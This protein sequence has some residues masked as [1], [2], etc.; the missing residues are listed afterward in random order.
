M[1]NDSIHRRSRRPVRSALIRLALAPILFA[2]LT[3]TAAAKPPNIVLML[4]DNVGFGELGVYAGGVL[5]GAPTPRLDRLAAEGMRFTNFN[6]EVECSP[7]RSA[8]MTGR[9]PVRSGTWRA[10]SPGLPGGLAPWE[11]TIA[12]VLNG[13]GYDTAIFGKVAPRRFP[14]PFPD[15][16][17]LRRVVGLPVLDQRGRVHHPRRFRRQGRAGAATARREEGGSGAAGGALH[18]GKPPLH[19]RAHR[20]SIRGVHPRARLE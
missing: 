16:S 6:V 1:T 3:G 17:R 7:S 19:R 18:A 15:R 12:E 9:L 8:L 5:R 10:G 11:R 2:T 13:T 4:S 14:G 20:R